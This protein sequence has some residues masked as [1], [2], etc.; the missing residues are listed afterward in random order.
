MNKAFTFTLIKKKKAFTFTK[1]RCFTR[2]KS[3]YQLEVK[4]FY[5]IL[6]LINGKIR[7]KSYDVLQN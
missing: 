6:C 7:Q 2:N 3:M 4:N 1:G 5:Q